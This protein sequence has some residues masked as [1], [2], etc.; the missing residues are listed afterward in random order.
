MVGRSINWIVCRSCRTMQP[1]WSPESQNTVTLHQYGHHYTGFPSENAWSTS[2][3]CM[4]TRLY[5]ASALITS[6][7]WWFHM[8]HP[9]SYDLLSRTSSKF[10]RGSLISMDNG[11]L[12]SLPLHYGIICHHMSDPSSRPSV[13][14]IHA[15]SVIPMVHVR[16]VPLGQWTFLRDI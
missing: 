3:P 14:P 8:Y 11:L 15:R 5:M 16:L 1:V 4:F 7:R 9:A 12:P 13:P 10:P 6:V 2:L